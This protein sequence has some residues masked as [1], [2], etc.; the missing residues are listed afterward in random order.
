MVDGCGD[1]IC[2]L[3]LIVM[4]VCGFGSGV[5]SDDIHSLGLHS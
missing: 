4:T 2:D 3:S 5:A 1:P